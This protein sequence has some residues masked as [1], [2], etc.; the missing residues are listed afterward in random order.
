MG[1]GSYGAKPGPDVEA[2]VT[3][4]ATE[5]NRELTAEQK[6]KLSRNEGVEHL[7]PAYLNARCHFSI[8]FSIA[9]KI[10]FERWVGRWPEFYIY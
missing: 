1:L 4:L 2:W 9:E 3:R 6:E 7:T 8:P 5:I 10:G